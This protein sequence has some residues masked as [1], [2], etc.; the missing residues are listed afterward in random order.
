M[1]KNANYDIFGN[2]EQILFLTKAYVM[3]NNLN[4]KPFSE[5]RTKLN[6]LFLLLTISEK[7]SIP[8]KKSYWSMGE[9]KK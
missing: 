5:T 1:I 4:L 7:K 8:I 3:W 9:T 2:C 6:Y